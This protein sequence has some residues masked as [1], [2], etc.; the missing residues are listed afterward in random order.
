LPWIDASVRVDWRENYK[1]LKLSFPLAVERPKPIYEIPFGFIE[2]PAN[3]EEEPFQNWLDVTGDG[4]NGAAGLTLATDA[5][6]SADVLEGDLR[7]TVLRS[8][9]YAHHNPDRI[10]EGEAYR[11]IDQGEQFFRYRLMPHAG[12]LE[13]GDAARIAAQ[14]NQP[15]AAL[16]ESNHP[17]DLPSSRR[18]IVIESDQVTASALKRAEKRPGFVIHLHETAGTPV[19]TRIDCPL[20]GKSWSARFGPQE[21]KCFFL[22]DDPDA[23]ATECNLVEE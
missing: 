13:P 2:R 18:G 7:L 5:K 6:Y 1:M 22:P 20:A 12:P 9:A 4:A 11:F 3:G 17:G 14:L 21:I 10:E 23:P 19:E 15:P 8:P 16:V